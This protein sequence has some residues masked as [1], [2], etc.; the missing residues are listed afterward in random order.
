MEVG[1][2]GVKF[3]IEPP[4]LIKLEMSLEDPMP[5][6]VKGA[7]TLDEKVLHVPL[8]VCCGSLLILR[9]LAVATQ[10]Q[11]RLNKW[12]LSCKAIVVVLL[13]RFHSCDCEARNALNSNLRS[14]YSDCEIILIDIIWC[15]IPLYKQTSTKGTHCIVI[16]YETFIQISD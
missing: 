9:R 12:H 1:R 11:F 10:L 15:T 6:P 5:A 2:L 13:K 7:S 16:K 3:G 4:T 8:W 14:L